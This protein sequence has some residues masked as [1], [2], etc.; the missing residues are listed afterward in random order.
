[1]S[2]DNVELSRRAMDAVNRRD[3]GALL[4][5]MDDDVEAA[6]LMTAMEGSY[7]GHDGIRRWWE[8]LHDVWP[9]FSVE[10]LEVRDLG[11]VTLVALCIRGH[12]AGSDTPG[13]QRTWYSATV[14]DEKIVRW[15]NHMTEAEALE[16]AGLRE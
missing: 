6:P 11:D 4:A 14:R 12:A 3:L 10:V 1:M 13:E 7:R 8:N 16:A 9:D 15:S 2:Q 5:V